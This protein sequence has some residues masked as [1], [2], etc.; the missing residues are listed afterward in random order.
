MH[1]RAA[2]GGRL[3]LD[4]RGGVAR[5]ARRGGHGRATGA[6]P[7]LRGGRAAAAEIWR[8]PLSAVSAPPVSPPLSV[9]QPVCCARSYFHDMR[10][11]QR[12]V[13]RQK[14]MA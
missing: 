14:P 12:L 4:R 5:A 3:H 7:L 2:R 13:K 9:R 11:Q 8:R 10:A 1:G 6:Q